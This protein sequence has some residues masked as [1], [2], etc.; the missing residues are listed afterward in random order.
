[1]SLSLNRIQDHFI[2]SDRKSDFP[3]FWQIIEKY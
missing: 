3:N 2:C 1:M